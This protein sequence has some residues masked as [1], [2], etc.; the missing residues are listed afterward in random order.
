MRI[1][2]CLLLLVSLYSNILSKLVILKPSG[3]SR[4]YLYQLTKRPDAVATPDVRL[5]LSFISSSP[6]FSKTSVPSHMYFFSCAAQQK[7]NTLGKL[8]MKWRRSMG[9]PGR[10]QTQPIMGTVGLETNFFVEQ[11]YRRC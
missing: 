10:L 2:A 8:E 3:G 7:P 6:R 1:N 4:N 11:V 9:E 5:A